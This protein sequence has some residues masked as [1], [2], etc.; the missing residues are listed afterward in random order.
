MPSPHPRHLVTVWNPA[1][2]DDA[3][4]AHLELLLEQVTRYRRGEVGEDDVYVWWGKIR[5]PNRM[6]PLVHLEEILSLD[7][8]ELAGDLEPDVVTEAVH[9]YL[10]DYRRSEE[11]TSELQSRENLVCRLLLEKKNIAR[12]LLL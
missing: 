3:M 6:Q 4:E 10:P 1:T 5:S 2:A 8:E 12:A 11:H 7:E 9:L